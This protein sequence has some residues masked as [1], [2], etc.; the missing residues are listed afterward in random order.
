MVKAACKE[1]I[2]LELS[3]HEVTLK[4]VLHN[5][6]KGFKVNKYCNY[7]LDSQDLLQGSD[8]ESSL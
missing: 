3:S 6:K 4:R 8:G 5:H 7:S 2:G 1:K